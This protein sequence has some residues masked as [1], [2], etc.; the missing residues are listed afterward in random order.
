M[1][2]QE[3]FL[4]NNNWR[5]DAFIETGCS[6]CSSLH[7]FGKRPNSERR[8]RELDRRRSYFQLDDLDFSGSTD[9][10]L[11]DGVIPSSFELL[12]NYPNPFN[13]TTNIR[14]TILNSQ[15]TT[16]KVY[17][18]L[19]REVATLVNEQ[20]EAGTHQAQFDASGLASGTYMYRFT[21]GSFVATKMMILAR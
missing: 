7:R 13:P 19:G 17:D 10:T 14:F 18:V 6:L 4:S 3:C 9:V 20:K 21:A 16:L 5:H 15:L 11:L 12:Q 1:E 2:S 8:I